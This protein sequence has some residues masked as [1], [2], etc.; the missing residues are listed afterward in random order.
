MTRGHPRSPEITRDHPRS[1]EIT[2]DHPRLRD[3]SRLLEITREIRPARMSCLCLPRRHRPLRWSAGQHSGD[4]APP[5]GG[6]RCAAPRSYV[7]VSRRAVRCDTE[8]GSMMRL[9]PVRQIPCHYS[10]HVSSLSVSRERPR[11]Q[12]SRHSSRDTT[13]SCVS[14]LGASRWGPGC[15]RAAQATRWEGQRPYD[16]KARSLRRPAQTEL[17]SP[18]TRCTAITASV[19]DQRARG[20]AN[21]TPQN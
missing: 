2:R 8:S 3:Y 1:L 18:H 13:L 5:W 11:E 19:T 21:R 12:L 6:R 9:C 16:C 14:T 7:T 4:R 20:G 15:G 10:C 17:L